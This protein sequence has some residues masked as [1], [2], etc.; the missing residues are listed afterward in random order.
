MT[1]HPINIYSI[2]DTTYDIANR[3]YFLNEGATPIAVIPASGALL[4]AKSVQI[5]KAPIDGIPVKEVK[6]EVDNF[7]T[8][9][10]I[11]YIVSNL[12][13]SAYNGHNKEQLLTIGD[14]VYINK[15]NPR[16]VGCLFL[17]Q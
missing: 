11:Y 12:Y 17:A 9:P 13:K 2:S 8:E 10:G 6:W 16:P 15:D 1:P 7:T 4:N 14:P 3:K 5:D